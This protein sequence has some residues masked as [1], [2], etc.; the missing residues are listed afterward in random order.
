VKR[1]CHVLI[2]MLLPHLPGVAQPPGLPVQHSR[3]GDAR[4]AQ[5]IAL[6][7]TLFFDQRLSRD[8]SISCANCHQPERAFSD[9]LALAQ[10]LGVGTRN[11]PSLLNVRYNRSQFWDGRSPSL[12]AQAIQ[13]FL[14]P[15][16]HGLSDQRAL[17]DILASKP[18]YVA[19]FRAA[20]PSARNGITVAQASEA[21]ASFERTLTAGNSPF[22]R[23][24]Y[25]REPAALAPGALRGLAL[26]QGAARCAS[27]HLIGKSD[28]LFTDHQFHSLG[29]DLQRLGPVL[30]RLAARV[31][32]APGDHDTAQLGRYTVTRNP[33]DI[34]KFRTPSLRNVAQT[35][36]YMHDGSVATLEEAVEL[37]LYYRSTQ[38]AQALV[39]TAAE[40]AD[41][42]L[43]LKALSSDA[44]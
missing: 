25:L 33:A 18:E 12:E 36:P 37:E 39:L 11:T 9:G 16:E 27:C 15:R 32:G 34:G 2:L 44:H 22:D 40:R 31:D 7:K 38:S 5:K 26:F 24:V 14:N 19:A 8:G 20:F 4:L 23:H 10:G 42:V 3:A 30:G 13:P 1:S 35:A 17:I 28:A 6:G 43:F 21:L 41:L 29:I